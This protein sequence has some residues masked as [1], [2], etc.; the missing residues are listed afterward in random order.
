MLQPEKLV[1]A[2]VFQGCDRAELFS[3]V[4]TLPEKFREDVIDTMAKLD[5]DDPDNISASVRIDNLDELVAVLN[6]TAKV[7]C[8][9]G[10]GVSC[11]SEFAAMSHYASLFATDGQYQ[12]SAAS[13]SVH[14]VSRNYAAFLEKVSQAELALSHIRDE[15]R[16]MEACKGE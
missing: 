1:W 9:H 12:Q 16:A 14:K 7:R 2:V 8:Y 13:I 15:V 5:D 4:R 3:A 11:R 6:A 10:R